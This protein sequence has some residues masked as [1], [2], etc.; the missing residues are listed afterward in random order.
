[1]LWT[2][3]REERAPTHMVQRLNALRPPQKRKK[4]EGVRSFVLEGG[5]RRGHTDDVIAAIAERST[6]GQA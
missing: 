2:H 3:H 5:K 1:M 4:A 6:A